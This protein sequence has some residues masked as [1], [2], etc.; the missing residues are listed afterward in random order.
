ME[1]YQRYL[2]DLDTIISFA[3]E[4]DTPLAV[5]IFPF[6]FQ[7]EDNE[8]RD[9][10]NDLS[11]YLEQ[12]GVRHLDFTDIWHGRIVEQNRSFSEFFLDDDHYT[13]K[14]HQVVAE[15]S[16]AFLKQL[17]YLNR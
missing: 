12:K 11:S 5:L 2:Q 13:D 14:G 4:N 9:I 1:A 10:Q 6:K 16:L 7:V 3:K 17:N 15:E 8:H